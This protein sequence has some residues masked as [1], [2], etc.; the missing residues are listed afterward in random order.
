[1]LPKYVEII[2]AVFFLIWLYQAKPPNLIPYRSVQCE[3]TSFCCI[4]LPTADIISTVE[5]NHDGEFLATGDKGG[6]VVIFQRDG[7][8]MRVRLA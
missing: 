1:M 5:F 7:T 3:F 2:L 4:P 8:K 6:R